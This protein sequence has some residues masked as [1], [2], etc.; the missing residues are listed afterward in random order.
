MGFAHG[1]DR[2]C[3]RASSSSRRSF[4]VTTRYSTPPQRQRDRGGWPAAA[5][6]DSGIGSLPAG[7]RSAAGAAAV[8]RRKATPAAAMCT[9][10]AD[11]EIALAD[12]GRAA[13]HQHAARR[14]NTRRDDVLGHRAGVI[15][16]AQPCRRASARIGG[17]FSST[18]ARGPC[19]STC[20]RHSRSASAFRRSRA[21]TAAASRHCT[22][23]LPPSRRHRLIRPS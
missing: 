23:R 21:R 20:R 1:I 16:Q 3:H 7:R 6:A 18:P 5:R 19:F 17:G 4:G 12:L 11:D 14:Q 8:K 22:G 15:E 13:Q 2:Q 10:N 9:S